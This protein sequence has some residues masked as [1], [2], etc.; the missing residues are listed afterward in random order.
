MNIEVCEDN[1]LGTVYGWG[2]R[3]A[4]ILAPEEAGDGTVP[5][6]ASAALIAK[7]GIRHG[8]EGGKGAGFD[9]A[10]ACNDPRV[11]LFALESLCEIVTESL[12]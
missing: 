6:K 7:K 5:G 2:G 11:R 9:H 12:P 10:D 3:H 1:G 4:T 8:V